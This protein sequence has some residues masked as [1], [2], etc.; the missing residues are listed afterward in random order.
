MAIPPSFFQIFT[1]RHVQPQIA[2]PP[3]NSF[4]HL[5]SHSAMHES[6]MATLYYAFRMSPGL[7]GRDHP[8]A[9][10]H[11]KWIWYHPAIYI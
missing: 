1:V 9:S 8:P 10:R 11:L 6:W 2:P 3:Y 5:R 7:E 4:Q